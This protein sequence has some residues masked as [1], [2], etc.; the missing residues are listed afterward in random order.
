MT[1]KRL[2]LVE[3]H[4]V[5]A[6]IITPQFLGEH[7]LAALERRC[8]AVSSFDD[9]KSLVLGLFTR[10]LSD[11]VEAARQALGA[12]AVFEECQLN[13]RLLAELKPR[14]GGGRI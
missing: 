2:L 10:P 12:S 11:C 9:A 1:K 8:S 7:D 5:F 4:R 14:P 3:N 6:T 13:A